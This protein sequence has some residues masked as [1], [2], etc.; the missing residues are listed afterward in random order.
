MNKK[1]AKLFFD[2][3]YVFGEEGECFERWNLAVP[4]QI[5]EDA[6]DRFKEVYDRH[7]ER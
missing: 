7:L 1:E 4:T 3:G 6:L 5:I 2:E